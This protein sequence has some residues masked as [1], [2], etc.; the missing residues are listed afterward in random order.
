M[1]EGLGGGQAGA[2]GQGQCCEQGC[3]A[4]VGVD[5]LAYREGVD[6]VEAL[7]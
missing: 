6:Q 7:E 2:Q 3:E 1:Q 5:D 4:G